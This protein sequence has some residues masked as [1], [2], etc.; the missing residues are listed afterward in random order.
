MTTLAL[1]LF[2]A[3]VAAADEVE[4]TSGTI[5]EGKVE[6]L[7]DSIKIVKS[8]GSATY[9]KS[10]V[11]KITPKKTVEEIYEE[12]SRDL[13]GD[14]L[15]GHLKLARW[16][17]QQK[18]AKESILEFKKI[19]VLDTDHEEARL[20]AGFQKVNGKWLS[21]DEA[22]AAKGLVKH[23][24]KWMTPEQ[25]DLDLALEE[26]KELEKAIQIEVTAQIARL[27][28]PDE[29]KRADAQ[30]ALAK[31][32]DKHKV[33]AYIAALQSPQRETRKFL[34]EELGRMKDPSAL[35]TLVRRSLWD[36]DESLR[37]V[38]FHAVQDI[39]YADTALLYVPFLAEE[40]ISARIRCVDAMS[41][42]KDIRVVPMLIQALE[43]NIELTKS[44]E[45]EGEAMTAAA[46]TLTMADGS[47][48]T[49]PR[50]MRAKVADP[51]DKNSRLRL[52]Q[53]KA[54]IAN[55]LGSITGQNFGDD[56]SR[57]RAWME[58][59]RAGN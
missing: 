58:R 28:S 38:A 30:A 3:S 55:T 36:E 16:C 49:L 40:S 6:D 21:E 4:L 54:S 17:S 10:M 22:N 9:P 31:I 29:K 14:D 59:K 20:G 34:F 42:F 46:R 24:G 2:A 8:N 52:Q 37:L 11:R 15:E 47:T 32:D 27:K 45:K 51:L 57:W 7:G 18:L 23:K 53:E 56:V 19:L 48:I 5:I 39:G 43:N 35:K 44:F 25:R 12:R 41:T 1:F 50:S 13:K 26:Q 33:K